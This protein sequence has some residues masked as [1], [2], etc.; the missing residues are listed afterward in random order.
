MKK[1]LT[2]DDE[3]IQSGAAKKQWKERKE[4]LNLEAA[5]ASQ[6]HTIFWNTRI[7]FP[8][9]YSGG[10]FEQLLCFV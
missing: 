4:M 5:E 1:G 6:V 10:E 3:D 2:D 7:L 9:P 8:Q